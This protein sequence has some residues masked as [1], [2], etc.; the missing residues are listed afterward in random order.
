MGG[1]GGYSHSGGGGGRASPAGQ[2]AAVKRLAQR[3]GIYLNLAS[4]Q[5]Y[6]INPMYINETL[7][8]VQFIYTHFP[9]MAGRVKYIDAEAGSP[10]AY[11]SAGGDGGLH[12]GALRASDA[13]NPC[14][15]L[16]A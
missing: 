13:A 2:F 10:N 6:N 7:Q 3:M 14:K 15:A 16:G 12:M 5:Q 1:R 9:V 11:A 4:L 8:S